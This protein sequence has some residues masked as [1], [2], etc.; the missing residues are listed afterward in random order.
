M[1]RI[2]LKTLSILIAI[3]FIVIEKSFHNHYDVFGDD[4]YMRWEKIHGTYYGEAIGGDLI[5]NE[6]F[7]DSSGNM[8]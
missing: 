8:L 6:K 7:E 3:A 4:I 2:T 5:Y 1:K